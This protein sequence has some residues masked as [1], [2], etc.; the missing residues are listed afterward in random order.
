[1]LAGTKGGLLEEG[2]EGY[3]G[4]FFFDFLDLWIKS[5]AARSTKQQAGSRQLAASSQLRDDSARGGGSYCCV[6]VLLLW[7]L[8]AVAVEA[9]HWAKEPQGG[10]EV[11]RGDVRSAS[12]H[13]CCGCPWSKIIKAAKTHNSHKSRKPW[14]KNKKTRTENKPLYRNIPS[15]ITWGLLILLQE[16]STALL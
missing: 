8:V 5:P 2:F 10:W 11:F 7:L 3:S 6:A 9:V 1:M 12:P 4:D 16:P 13:R 14:E 15:A